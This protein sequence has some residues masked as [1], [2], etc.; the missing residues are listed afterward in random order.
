MEA[1]SEDAGTDDQVPQLTPYMPGVPPQE[2][3][4]RTSWLSWSIV[5]YIVAMTR[6]W[7]AFRNRSVLGSGERGEGIAAVV[8]GQQ[9]GQV[10]EER[11]VL[12]AAGRGGG[13]GAFGEPLAA[14]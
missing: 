2:P 5:V 11:S 6:G 12:L 9:F 7:S 14:L 4:P 10:C 13:E 1:N 8:G 3:V